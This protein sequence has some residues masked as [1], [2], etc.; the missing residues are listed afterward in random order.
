MVFYDN[1]SGMRNINDNR[2]TGS[3]GSGNSGN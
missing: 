3:S 1:T 2:V